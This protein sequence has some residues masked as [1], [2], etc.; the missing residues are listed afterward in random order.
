MKTLNPLFN[1]FL[2]LFLIS[3]CDFNDQPAPREATVNFH[4]VDAPAPYDE[5]WIE[6]LA[7]R[8]KADY[9][10]SDMDED[11][12]SWEEIVYG[13]SKMINL[14]DLTGGN[15]LL[16]G[17]EEF[18]AGELEQ[19]RLILGENNYLM[20]GNQKTEL[21][22]P[23]AQQSGLKIKINQAIESRETYDLVIDFDAAQSI[24]NAGNSGKAILKPVLRAYMEESQGIEGQIS[25]AEAR[26]VQV[27]V[28]G[29]GMETNTFVDEAGNYSIL[30]L[31]PGT[32]TM[33]FTPNE[34][35]IPQ[36][37]TGIVVEED[38]ITVPNVVDLNLKK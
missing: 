29:N 17:T 25:Q 16:L 8:V 23:S 5:V 9:P 38:Q 35:Y 28:T 6:V 20:K 15:S 11:D 34:S 33:T 37:F 10:G 19:I 18:P 1:L 26:P 32:Y 14:L 36:T 22:T 27:T 21:T 2:L 30:G 4:L 3:G 31:T 7:I 12:S 24:V 13:G